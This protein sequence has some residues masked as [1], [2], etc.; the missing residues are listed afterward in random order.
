MNC[1][2]CGYQIPEGAATCVACGQAVN[3]PAGGV[4][5]ATGLPQSGSPPSWLSRNAKV[6]IPLGCLGVVLLFGLFVGGVLTFVFS[7]FRSSEPYQQAM[8]RARRNPQ[9]VAALGTPIEPGWLMTGNLNES[10]ASGEAELSIPIS[11]PKGKGTIFVS[12]RKSAG[13][14]EFRALIVELDGGERIDLLR[15][16][17]AP[18]AEPTTSSLIPSASRQGYAFGRGFFSAVER[19]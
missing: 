2:N 15:E 9:V 12:A 1:R 5:G 16:K 13:K 11:G 18:R 10:G 14:W 8:E 6:A 17:P 19:R 3:A 7:M 4:P